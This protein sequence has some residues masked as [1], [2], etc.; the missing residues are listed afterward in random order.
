M[1]GS[2]C[3]VEPVYFY[4]KVYHKCKIVGQKVDTLKTKIQKLV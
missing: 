3:L 4:N 1:F 2:M